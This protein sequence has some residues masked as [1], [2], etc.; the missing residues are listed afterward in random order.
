M[1][2]TNVTITLRELDLDQE[3]GFAKGGWYSPTEIL[4]RVQ[5]LGVEEVT[6]AAVDRAARYYDL[7]R[8]HELLH[9]LDVGFGSAELVR[10][11]AHD[12]QAQ[13]KIGYTFPHQEDSLPEQQVAFLSGLFHDI[14]VGYQGNTITKTSPEREIIGFIAPAEEKKVK[15]KPQ[16]IKDAIG[17]DL[18]GAIQLYWCGQRIP[19][20][21]AVRAGDELLAG[22]DLK[23]LGEPKKLLGQFS[24]YKILDAIWYHDG[25]YPLRG[26]AEADAILGDRVR[27]YEQQQVPLEVIGAGIQ[28]LLGYT[29]VD[30][31]WEERSTKPDAAYLE[32]MVT[33]KA[34]PFLQAIAGTS[35]Y[36]FVRE[37][38]SSRGRG[39]RTLVSPAFWRGVDL[40]PVA[41]EQA[42]ADNEVNNAFSHELA[43]LQQRLQHLEQYRGSSA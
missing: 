36:D 26:F 4:Q 21:L 34:G 9:C 24:P 43:T 22:S 5:E 38:L 13:Q 1:A 3:I 14:I 16:Y 42:R 39:K 27:L 11:L 31:Q 8:V 15:G 2:D 20:W 33:K 35:T 28:K 23:V 41:L 18:R 40:M 7:A 37:D 30:P 19:A 29:E 17:D 10:Q 25:N 12:P 32:K 6:A